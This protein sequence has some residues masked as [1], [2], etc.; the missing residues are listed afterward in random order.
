MR[1]IKF[2]GRIVNGNWVFGNYAHLKQD[3]STVKEGHYISNS[4][5]SPFAFLVRP[6]TIGQFTGLTDK[7]GK[8]IYEG[9]IHRVEIEHSHGDE[10]HYFICTWLKEFGSFSW[11][12]SMNY[13]DYIDNGLIAIE[14]ML[15]DG[16]P[17]HLD[18]D[19]CEQIKIIGNIHENPDLLK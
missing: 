12:D 5:G 17:L 9:D 14:W 13:Q 18:F 10:R 6:E 11:I 15:N 8:E 3:F 2:R 19:D 7:N 4:K 16:I 1:E